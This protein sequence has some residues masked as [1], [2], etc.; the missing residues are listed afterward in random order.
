MDEWLALTG[1]T[2]DASQALDCGLAD[3]R[4]EA[5]QL[6]G[7]WDALAH[8]DLEVQGA[9]ATWPAISLVATPA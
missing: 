6:P 4:G 9:R 5:D 7:A 2:I 3:V 8:L 1:E